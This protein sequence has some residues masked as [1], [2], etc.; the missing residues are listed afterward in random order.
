MANLIPASIQGAAQVMSY[1]VILQVTLF[2]KI[3]PCFLR[4]E[5]QSG[6]ATVV[7]E[8]LS[9][10]LY[11]YMGMSSPMRLWSLKHAEA[12]GYMLQTS[13]HVYV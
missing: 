9:R 3:F 12:L 5:V 6:A 1:C 10:V 4:A 8:A 13:R 11:S 7:C 2:R